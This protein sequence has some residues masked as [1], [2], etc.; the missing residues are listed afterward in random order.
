MACT[1]KYTKEN[2]GNFLHYFNGEFLDFILDNGIGENNFLE[3]RLVDREIHWEFFGSELSSSSCGQGVSSSE[4]GVEFSKIDLTLKKSGGG[5]GMVREKTQQGMVKKSLELGGRPTYKKRVLKR[6]DKG[7][8]STRLLDFLDTEKDEGEEFGGSFGSE[9]MVSMKKLYR[10]RSR[11]YLK[12][13]LERGQKN[14]K[15]LSK[16]KKTGAKAKGSEQ[17]TTTKDK[18]DMEEFNLYTHKTLDIA[19]YPKYS[20]PDMLPTKP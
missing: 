17:K 2:I 7:L 19:S 10:S 1:W 14:E 8:E 9:S 3:D 20:C 4:E 16:G 15:G 18:S 5:A 11:K 12:G 6:N 13:K